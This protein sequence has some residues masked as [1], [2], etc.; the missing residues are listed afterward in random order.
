MALGTLVIQSGKM[1]ASELI[2]RLKHT[3][4]EWRNWFQITT[5]GD[6]LILLT[7]KTNGMQHKPCSL[8]FTHFCIII[9]LLS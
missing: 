1:Y 3:Q 6:Q 2:P 8:S 7:K 5:F 9:S 4:Q